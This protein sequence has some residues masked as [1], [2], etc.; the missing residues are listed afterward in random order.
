MESLLFNQ[1]DVSEETKKAVQ[2]MGFEEA[3]PIQAKA[4]PVI[5][6]GNDV[7]AQAPTGTGKTCAFGIP[8]IEG[9][10]SNDDRVQVLILCPTRELVIQTT[11]ELKALSKY[12]EGVRSLPIYGGQQIDRQITGLKKKPQ[13]I[14]GTPGRVMDHLRR[15]T[16][17]LENLKMLILD[18]ADEMLNMGFREDIDIILESVPGNRQFV[19]FSA[20]LPKAILDI[21]DKYQTNTVK[22]NVVHKELTVP[23]VEQFYLE[24]RESNKVEVLS[25]LIDANNFKLSVV[26][27]NTKKRVDDLCKDLQARGYSAEALHGDMKQ[28]QRD[29]VM[30]RFRNGF[31]DI[32]IATDVAARGID[33]D[34]V[35]AVFN[36]DLPSDE[37]YY[38]HRIGRTGRAKREGA[39]FSFAAG[40]EMN[41]LRDIQRYTKSKIKLMK[42]PTIEDIE[43]NILSG[44]LGEV[45]EVL[46]DGKLNKYMKYIEQMLEELDDVET[47][48]YP[49]SVEV[50]AAFLKL[51]MKNA[52]MGSSKDVNID[53]LSRNRTSNL[54]SYEDSNMV[55]LFINVGK[56]DHLTASELIKFIAAH[57]T[58]KGKQI[59]RIDLL[60]K[61]SFFEI[62]KVTLG[63]AM[64][65]LVDQELKGRR[66]NLEVANKKQ[67]NSGKD[68]GGKRDRR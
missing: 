11:E 57:T 7:I 62:P 38:V 28:L 56:K 43:E 53:E 18:E 35:D 66:V 34:D 6:K 55:R 4:I 3:T 68:R 64:A 49:T 2:D 1:L 22:I 58:I 24:V 60:D 41:K 39:S 8:A 33:V 21:A 12:K 50:A 23:T 29:S 13:I 37:E 61:F 44:I 65:N 25:R 67:G 20:T 63:E 32:L 15:K 26:F 51:S 45:K 9:I 16:L 36:Y 10:D 31:V 27:C 30:N 17:R 52:V 54:D 59:G 46:Q 42:P 40:R 19:L 48:T 5:L 47:D 14:I